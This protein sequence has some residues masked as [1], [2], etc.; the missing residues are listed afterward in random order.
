MKATAYFALA[1]SAFLFCGSAVQA[2]DVAPP[3][4][5][6]IQSLDSAINQMQARQAT[7]P[8]SEAPVQTSAAVPASAPA[9][10]ASTNAAEN[11]PAT[12]ASAESA[13]KSSIQSPV[14]YIYE[15]GAKW[16][17]SCRKLAPM[18]EETA[19]KYEGFAEY[20][21]VNVDKNQELV[22]QLNVAQIPTVMIVDKRGRMLNR[23]VGLQQGV[24]LEQILEHYKAQ[25]I[26]S[27]ARKQIH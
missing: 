27:A 12:N 2:D 18:V 10:P 16:C 13:S 5:P 15:F 6:A 24:Q 8:M 3:A 25:T 19:A 22:R 9:I 21:P 14:V 11:S 17:P 7:A 26:A 20:I 23:L 1:F 4:A